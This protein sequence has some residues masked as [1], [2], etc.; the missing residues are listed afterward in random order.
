MSK[1]RSR[2]DYAEFVASVLAAVLGVVGA[3]VVLRFDDVAELVSS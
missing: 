1:V 3:V 2:A